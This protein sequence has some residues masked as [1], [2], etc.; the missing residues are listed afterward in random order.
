MVGGGSTHWTPTLLVDF[1]NSPVL[2]DAEVTLVDTAPET[3]PPMVELARHLASSRSI[4]LTARAATALEEGLEGAEFV[5]TTLSVGG[6]TAMA[7]DIEIPYRYGVRQPVGD[8][9]GPGGILRSLRS[10]PVVVGIAR[11][12][13][14]VAPGALLVNV[15]NPLTALCRA[16]TRETSVRAVGLCNELVGLSFVLSLLFDV[17][18]DRIRPTVGGVNHLPLVTALDLDG[19]D[20]LA[21]L[22]DLLEDP[23]SRAD[24]PIWMDPPAAM[25][26]RKRSPGTQWTKGDVLANCALKLELFRR[27]GILPGSA[28]THVSEFFPWFLTPRSDFG[29]DW[30]VYHYGIAGHVADKQADEAHLARLLASEEIPRWGSGELVATLLEGVVGGE[31]RDL[32]VNLPNTGQVANL[33]TGTVVECIGVADGAGVRAR[34]TVEV[35]GVLAARLA[36]IVASQEL[37]VSAA[38]TG[39]RDLVVEAMLCDPLA[40][41]LPYED[42]VSMT[43]EMLAAT[44]PWLP[45]FGDPAG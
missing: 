14:H 16:V 25:H 17:S 36:Q 27:S 18:F 43:D 34:D 12:V 28:D 6:F 26:W 23:G 8:S 31:P 15:S 21:R 19:Q 1:A 10:V 42:V 44:S 29:R 2:Q 9:V 3:L 24:E 11:A 35:T 39:R 40:S 37:T 4:G 41:A 22:R 32:P 20:G 5:L 7:H 30:G 45:Q 13:E 38:L 33:P